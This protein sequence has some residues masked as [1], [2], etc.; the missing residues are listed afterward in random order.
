MVV[1]PAP[2][3]FKAV[4]VMVTENGEISGGVPAVPAAPKSR[5]YIPAVAE[6]QPP[7]CS[8]SSSISDPHVGYGDLYVWREGVWG[9]VL[10]YPCALQ[11]SLMPLHHGGLRGEL[12]SAMAT[13][14]KSARLQQERVRQLESAHK[15]RVRAIELQSWNWSW[16]EMKEREDAAR[17]RLSER[18]GERLN[19]LCDQMG[20][21]EGERVVDLE[22]ARE[23]REG[24]RE[25]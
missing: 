5:Y 25:E 24:R 16:A 3:L 15:G 17:E 11:L 2:T 9:S 23:V 20:L 7:T 13:G 8:N 22:A 12:H 6:H 1:T 4:R 19:Q 14:V 21:S 18:W 10:C